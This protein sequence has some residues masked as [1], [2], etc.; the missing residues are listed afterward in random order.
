MASMSELSFRDFAGAILSNDA[1]RATEVLSELL[2]LD[3]VAGHGA[4]TH[5]RACIERDPSFLGTA[6]MGLRQAVTT[7][8]DD[9]TSALLGEYFGLSSA[10][11]PA[12][13]AA[14]RKKYPRS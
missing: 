4:T 3:P 10:A 2:G 8:T 1:A 7:G 11:V 12:A 9:E 5:F 14:L 13:L 6:A